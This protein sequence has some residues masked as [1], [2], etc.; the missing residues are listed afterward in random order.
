MIHIL[1]FMSKHYTFLVLLFTAFISNAQIVNIPD[2]NFK[3]KLL[4]ASPSNGIAR[5]ATGQNIKIDINDDEEIQVSEVL[6][7]HALNVFSSSIQNM[8]GIEAFLNLR[9]L[10][11][12]T[13][14][15]T[16]L[17]ITQNTALSYFYC[18]DNQLTNLDVSQNTNLQDLSCAFNQL[19]SLDL[20]QNTTLVYLDCNNNQLENLILP[21]S[22]FLI[23]VNCN[24]NQLEIINISQC[25]SLQ[26]FNC[27]NNNLTSIDISQTQALFILDCSFNQLTFLDLSNNPE[28]FTVFCN[29]N[30]ITSI[31][32][33]INA[34]PNDL[35]CNNNLIEFFDMNNARV[36]YL[37]LS[38]NLNLVSINI[39]N[40][41][42]YDNVIINNTPNLQYICV[43]EQDDIEFIFS[44]TDLSNVIINSYCSFE[45][46]GTFYT[47]QGNN[48]FDS[49]SNGCDENDLNFSNQKFTITNGSINGTIIADQSGTYSIPVQSGSHTITPVFE[50]PSYFIV[51]PAS[52]TVD[53]PSATSPYTQD[54]CISPNGVKNDLEVTI[55]PLVAARPG[56]D[57]HYRIIYENKGN[58]VANGSLSFTFDDAIMD[59][60]SAS[61]VN[62][63]AGTNSLSWNYANLVPFETR[64]ID[65]IF[66]INSPMETP[67]VNGDDV[68]DYT[69]TI[70][71][72]TDETPNDNTF[73]LNQTVVNSYDPNDK[74]CLEGLSISPG[75][76]GDYVHYLIRFENTG[77]YPAE[78]I[79]V[80]DD[81]DI[82][83]FDISTLVPL[84]SSH[85]FVTRLTNTNKIEFIFENINLPF[86]NANNDG[87]VAFKIKT[88]PTLVV[89]NTFSNKANIYFDYNF[90]IVTNNF[91]TTVQALGNADFEFNTVFCLS[92]VPT[93]DVLTI[94]A[95]E[96]VVMTSISIYNTLGQLV[97]VHTSPNESIDISGL[98]SGN[99]LIKIISDRGSST[100]KFIKE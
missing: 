67:A 91:T 100:G 62:D 6:N 13:N 87:Y 64:E 15:L 89:G 60:V 56:F 76:V 90:P 77:T 85:N 4:A 47:I 3:A 14:Q 44:N 31:Q 58:Q 53:F 45:P 28:L 17:D 81:I 8:T 48:K 18:G 26:N 16:N 69:A 32:M 7:V 74:T 52:A 37:D 55:I 27:N 86:D 57:A 88:K 73:V 80:K 54:F 39:K 82:T 68:L 99:Y 23:D 95:K 97:Q 70:V 1:L 79:V 65:L 20:T 9:T 29:N 94:T 66:N 59:L 40:G 21:I 96:N 43:D 50:N 41:K 25:S 72:A 92:P 71:G 22:S 46:G 33:S 19:T 24:N 49:N 42:Y 83:K 30:L 63:N 35:I 5:N 84:S 34:Y 38:N 2:A 36:S 61:P 51:S 10:D 11:C 78:N 93:K 75:M 12:S 98:S